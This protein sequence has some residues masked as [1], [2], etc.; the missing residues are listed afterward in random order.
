MQSRGSQS[1]FAAKRRNRAILCA[2]LGIPLTAEK[3]LI[4][5]IAEA[6]AK[7]LAS[8]LQCDAFHL[9]T[10]KERLEEL[11]RPIIDGLDSAR[12]LGAGRAGA[13]SSRHVSCWECVG[14]GARGGVTQTVLRATQCHAVK[15]LEA[16]GWCSV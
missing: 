15:A 11:R 9:D 3:D 12:D 6:E 16:R 5:E 1:V 7:L 13:A 10:L 2:Q 8:G 4:F 14:A